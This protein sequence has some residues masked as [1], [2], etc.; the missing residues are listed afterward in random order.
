MKTT[1]FLLKIL[2]I[3]L[4]CSCSSDDQAAEA[5]KTESI[6]IKIVGL[7]AYRFPASEGDVLEVYGTISTKLELGGGSDEQ[8]LWERS[9]ENYEQIGPYTG[10][11]SEESEHVFTIAKEKINSDA[12]IEV[13]ANLWDKDPDGNPDD[14][15]GEKT[16]RFEAGWPTSF[17]DDDNPT[18][19][20]ILLD[21][22]D[23]IIFW[24]YVTIEHI[25]D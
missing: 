22:F 2:M 5:E 9:R 23:G 3:S 19:R 16:L 14:F 12:M 18:R 11:N 10:I 1:H 15:L 4:L 13:N 8:I 24:V 7:E 21:R 6:R 25:R 20:V 17:T